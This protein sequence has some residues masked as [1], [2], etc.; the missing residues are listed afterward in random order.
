[1][2]IPIA[3]KAPQTDYA[4]SFVRVNAL[5]GETANAQLITIWPE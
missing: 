5:G 4:G 2:E 3:S 1:M